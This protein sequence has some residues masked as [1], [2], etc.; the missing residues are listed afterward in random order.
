MW[1]R[2]LIFSFQCDCGNKQFVI[3]R[4]RLTRS[5][6]ELLKPYY[7]ALHNSISRYGSWCTK[8]ENGTLHHWKMLSED[9][10]DVTEV[11]IPP[12]PKFA[13]VTVL[14]AMCSE[15][16]KE[17]VLFDSRKNGYDA[18]TSEDMD[19]LD[20]LPHFQN[21]GKKQYILEIKIENDES[22]EAFIENSGINCSE[23]FYSD[24][25]SW[26]I[27]WGIDENCKRRKLFEFET[28]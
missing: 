26:I 6:R 2:Y 25:F 17:Y 16:G 5:E 8:D 11:F 4:N 15:C 7:D 20:Y 24:S 1:L 12:K 14:K 3:A 19:D 9:Q 22:L 18:M 13:S 23:D 28:A 27:I 10:N 21:Y